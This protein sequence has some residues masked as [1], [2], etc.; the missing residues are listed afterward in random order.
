MSLTFE[1]IILTVVEIIKAKNGN[2][3]YKFSLRTKE[4]NSTIINVTIWSSN[5]TGRYANLGIDKQII[6]TGFWG[7]PQKTMEGF[8]VISEDKNFIVTSFRFPEEIVGARAVEVRAAGGENEYNNQLL[9]FDAIRKEAGFVRVQ[10]PARYVR[11]EDAVEVDGK[12]V[13]WGDFVYDQCPEEKRE[14]LTE[15]FKGFMRGHEALQSIITN[16]TSTNRGS[17]GLAD[18]TPWKNR[19][20]TRAKEVYDN[21][22]KFSNTQS[23]FL[24]EKTW[25]QKVAEANII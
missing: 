8:D 14:A 15:C 11:Q 7:K 4:K 13:Y 3:G 24:E 18:Y 19:A 16:S 10:N 25:E 22:N 20:I 17:T 6:I 9:K 21:K 12:W 2:N 5:C 23:I 1:G